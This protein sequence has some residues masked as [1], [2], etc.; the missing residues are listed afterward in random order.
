MPGLTGQGW[1]VGARWSESRS[2]WQA[3]CRACCARGT[4]DS[5]EEQESSSH[6]PGTPLCGVLRSAFT[7]R[8]SWTLGATWQ[9]LGRV[10][11]TAPGDSV[12][13]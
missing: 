13:V 9:D 10:A 12:M 11:D 8:A 2:L 5:A 4:S 1:F 3:G 7:T 6:V